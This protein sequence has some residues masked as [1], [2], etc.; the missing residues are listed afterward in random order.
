MR[1]SLLLGF[2]AL[3]GSQPVREVLAVEA[4]GSSGR[5]P[6]Q[7]DALLARAIAGDL[8][9]P[10]EGER[11]RGADGTERTWARVGAGE[12]GW[13]EGRA[14]RGGWAYAELAVAEA[15]AW[16]L[17]L[18]GPSFVLVDGQPH[19]GD[20]YVLGI[21]RV[22]LHL[23]A[24]THELLFRAGRGRLR[25]TL[26][27]AP[28]EVYLE[29]RD[30]TLPDLVRGEAGAVWLGI[31]VA[32][33][34]AEPAVGWSVRASAGAREVVTE[35]PALLES[36]LRKCAVELA[37]DGAGEGTLPVRL[38]LLG[39]G[40]QPVH[41]AR[42]ELAVRSPHELHCRTFPSA[43]DGS[44]QYY[45]VQPP[46]AAP[47]PGTSALFLSLHGAGV[48]AR[49]Q[50]ASYAP[51][52]DGYVIAPTNRRPFGF[53]WEDW[54]RL[55]ALE[56]LELASARYGTDP[57]RTYLT[58]HSMGGHG[59]W[60]LG[61]HFPGRFAAI[62]PSAGWRDFWGYA[63]GATFPDG[64]PI[65]DLLA[66]SANA[67]RTLLVER[68]L[69]AGGVYVLHGD[70]D[71]NVPVG[72][73]RAMRERL[74][75]FHPN[76][77]YYER[78]GAGHWWG[79]ECVDWPPLFE[80]LRRNELPEPG[81]LLELEFVTVDPG[82]SSRCQ[83]V[84][85]EEQ[86]RPLEPSRLGVRLDPDQRTL[87]LEAENVARASFDLA[88]FVERLAPGAPLTLLALERACELPFEDAAS[89]VSIVLEDGSWRAGGARDERRKSP[90]RGGP[91]KAAFRNRM[92]LVYGT[93]GTAQENA[94]ARAKARFDHETWRYRGNGAVD[95][96][97]DADY[98]AGD[99]AG[100][101]VVLYGNRDTNGAWSELLA[102]APFDLAR[103]RV[104]VGERVLEGDDLALLAVWRGPAGA[105]ASV[106]VIGGSG[107]V[108][109]RTTDHLPYFVSGV[110]Y[111]DWTVLGSDLWTRGLEGV[112]GAG[113]FAADWSAG[114]G[115]TA[116]WRE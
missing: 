8:S 10:R 64:D 25:A 55:D 43:I 115:S 23:A 17:A 114:P 40:A 45:A 56:V 49:G 99:F 11:I 31:P 54:G 16:R 65:G 102:G 2:L 66:R 44:V 80:F 81:T 4:L 32:N 18:E 62:A 34:G 78:P 97:S 85:I 19:A 30:R 89:P 71:D 109:C 86:E 79:S 88:P 69:R 67:S 77:A 87:R 33:A 104:R 20:P 15:G 63:G 84:T 94:W 108:G 51:K 75:A 105:R 111:P 93:R 73:A 52:P 103:G 59:T 5:S 107:L 38:E 98:A 92:V 50:A 22:P 57:A 106:A 72:E 95:V 27:R 46:P 6:I 91:F 39:P 90:E 70:A 14:F 76:F 82:V 28:A 9:A 35:L 7:T 116:A 101:N 112:R 48:E 26:E 58:G 29:E 13:F 47:E 24:G 42:L 3:Q 100:R 41:E 61:A 12:D 1:L 83:W 21:T 37:W 60:Q 36:S 53:D 68:N 113:F 110:G 96:V 74:A